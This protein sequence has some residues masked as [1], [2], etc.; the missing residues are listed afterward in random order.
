MKLNSNM[1]GWIYEINKD[2]LFIKS[3]NWT[4]KIEYRDVTDF[5]DFDLKLMFN[6]NE[7][8]NFKV[9]QVNEQEH[10]FLG[11]FKALH[12]QYSRNPFRF[13]LEETTKGFS[14][15][16]KMIIEEYSE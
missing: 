1:Y 8:I 6:I 7:K 13:D 15:L 2:C 11:S 10:T 16:S 4:G 14:T 5:A 9:I 3:A 12:L